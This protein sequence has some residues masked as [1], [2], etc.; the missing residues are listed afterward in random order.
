MSLMEKKN[1]DRRQ[2]FFLELEG[3]MNR[4]DELFESDEEMLDHIREAHPNEYDEYAPKIMS[5]VMLIYT[6]RNTDGWEDIFY[7]YP[8]TQSR[9]H[10]IGMVSNVLE[11]I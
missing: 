8:E 2:Q 6:T 11:L 5:G 3:L 1:K 9:F 10:N 7:V 4:Y